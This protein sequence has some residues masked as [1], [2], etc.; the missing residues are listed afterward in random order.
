MY[1]S[2]LTPDLQP[3]F[4]TLNIFILLLLCA[5]V[6]VREK[7]Q[8]VCMSLCHMCVYMHLCVRVCAHSGKPH[9]SWFIPSIV[10]F[11]DGIRSSGLH[12][13]HLYL[14]TIPPSPFH[15]FCSLF[16]SI[17]QP[18]VVQYVKDREVHA[19]NTSPW[20]VKAGGSRVQSHLWLHSEF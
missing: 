19:Y 10:R 13:N 17:K 3:C 14:V 2:Q 12:G 15:S 16:P 7:T 5:C 11:R 9:K 4:L 20:E 18:F 1:I 8:C 6:C